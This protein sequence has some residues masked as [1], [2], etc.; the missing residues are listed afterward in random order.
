M[1]V[2]TDRQVCV[3]V[4]VPYI[5]V[6]QCMRFLVIFHL[7]QDKAGV[8]FNGSRRLLEYELV[9]ETLTEETDEKVGFMQ[10]RW[11]RNSLFF[12]PRKKRGSL[13]L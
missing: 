10:V 9:D 13:Q 8:K 6:Y 4:C 2:H 12:C 1:N 3:C 11:G 5:C 7:K